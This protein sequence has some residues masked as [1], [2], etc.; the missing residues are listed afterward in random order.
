VAGVNRDTVVSAFLALLAEKSFNEIDLA[1]VAARSGVSLADLRGEFGST[2][3]MLAAFYRDV[4]KKVL[5]S[6]DSE[7]VDAPARERLFDVLM[8]RIET[9]QPHK[10]ALRSLFK[11]AQRDPS[12]ALGLNRLA[13]RSQQWMLSAAG[14]GSAGMAGRIRAQGLVYVMAKTLRVWFEDDDEGLARTMA[15][16]DRELA[17]GERAMNMLGG[18][19]NMVPGFT[20]R[21]ARRYKPDQDVPPA[22]N[23]AA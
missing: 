6:G 5:A 4:D 20:S 18:F 15:T 10:D 8:R 22:G 2:F 13:L 3:D 11:S 17:N 7:L 9:V 19:W 21:R 12:L 14:I 23:Q 16:L 1:A